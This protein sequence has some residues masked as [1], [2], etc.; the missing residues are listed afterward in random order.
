MSDLDDSNKTLYCA[1]S[2]ANQTCSDKFVA[3]FPLDCNNDAVNIL[4]NLNN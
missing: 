4:L 2:N 3:L 1:S